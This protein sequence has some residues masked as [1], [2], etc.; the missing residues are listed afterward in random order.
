MIKSL[1]AVEAWREGRVYG[2]HLAME[3]IAWTMANRVRAGHLDW[4]AC[5][6]TADA[7]KATLPAEKEYPNI[8]DAGFLALCQNID[9]IYDNAAKDLSCGGI[10]WLD[11]AKD[12]STDFKQK[13]IDNPLMTRVA[14]MNSLTI[15]GLKE[16]QMQPWRFL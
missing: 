14:C 4:M 9:A 7:Y 2:G 12:V 8:W 1:L 16:H 15:Y 6:K 3:M 5:L 11:I 10:Y 13:V